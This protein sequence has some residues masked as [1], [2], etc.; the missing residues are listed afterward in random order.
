MKNDGVF[1]DRRL[2]QA[3]DLIDPK[4]IAE[5]FDDL[6][7]PDTSKGYVSDKRG[8]HRAY[9][10]F[11][12]LAA[13]LILLSAAFP[14]AH[15]VL[16]NYDFQAGGWGSESA[17]E[18]TNGMYDEYIL[19]EDDL[20]QINEAYLQYM[21]ADFIDDGFEMS[22]EEIENYRNSRYS[23]FAL[24]VEEAMLKDPEDRFYF[25]KYGDT[26]IFSIRGTEAGNWQ[27]Y[28]YEL[29]EY[30]IILSGRAYV[31]YEY[32]WLSLGEAYNRRL[33]SDKDVEKLYEV[34]CKYI[35]RNNE[36][37]TALYGNYLKPIKD[38]EP[39]T[40][41]D[42]EMI[43]NV[44]N[45]DIGVDN[46]NCNLDAIRYLGTIDSY[47]VLWEYGAADSTH[48]IGI[49]GYDFYYGSSFYIFLYANG[50]RV[51]IEDAYNQGIIN[52]SFV[53]A[54][55]KRSTEYINYFG[56]QK[57]VP[58]VPITESDLSNINTAWSLKFGEGKIYAASLEDVQLGKQETYC[59]GKFDEV[60]V[61]RAKDLSE[62]NG[63][64]FT[65]YKVD[66][67]SFELL[68][69]SSQIWVYCNGEIIGLKEASDK[70]LLSKD[71]LLTVYYRHNYSY[72]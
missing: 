37:E 17:A 3:I 14:I 24:T 60:I 23:K 70:N 16:V 38:L 48:T 58:K 50:E 32:E 21:I 40:V 66:D 62:L 15:Y 67:C 4:F 30:E 68:W 27:T 52:D 41:G 72:D 10:Q 6:K 9:R 43:N 46:L 18:T 39:L 25:G 47:I 28:T 7:V 8:L 44:S 61:F 64:L 33:L 53:K 45:K 63:E 54:V 2:L 5:V 20:A 56:S 36:N 49:A 71:E 59:Y 1:T 12:A 13:C 69:P 29:G 65:E 51:K 55:Y 11:L 19:T 34:Y 35:R 22:E 57:I 26:F 31:V 42:L